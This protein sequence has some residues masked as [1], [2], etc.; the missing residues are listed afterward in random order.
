MR[1]LVLAAAAGALALTGCTLNRPDDPVVMT[2]AQLPAL[3]SVAAG[4]VV[5]FR[6]FNAWD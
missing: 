2:G 1:G 4:D 5:A 3:S 6:W